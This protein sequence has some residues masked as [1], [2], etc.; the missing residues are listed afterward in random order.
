M[1]A[2]RV[3]SGSLEAIK[4]FAVAAMVVDHVAAAFYGRDVSLWVEIVGRMAFPMFAMV[5][6][7]NLAR[8]GVDFL[9][10]A[11]RLALFG[12]LA[13]PAHSY[14]FALIDG[15]WPLNVMFTFSVAVAVIAA[16][17]ADRPAIA[18]G[19]FL[20]GGALV[21][22]WWP[23]VALVVVMWMAAVS[24]RPA[25]FALPFALSFTALCWINGNAWAI[26]ALPVVAGLVY[27]APVVARSRWAF[28]LVYPAHLS[29]FAIAVLLAT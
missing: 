25:A 27:A 20:L 22:F 6:G 11:K 8:P 17:R 5:I 28:Y 13:L 10:A 2:L 15:W 7:Y 3:S 24:R 21:E 1:T 29:L 16:L 12:F 14:L 26:A 19:V 4:W 18:L 9:K 23:G